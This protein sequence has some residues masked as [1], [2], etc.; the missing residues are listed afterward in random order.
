MIENKPRVSTDLVQHLE[1]LDLSM[2]RDATTETERQ[3]SM[4]FF[5][6]IRLYHRAVLWSIVLSTAIVMEGFDLVLI[7]SFFAFPQFTEHFG[8]RQPDGSYQVLSSWQSALTNGAL[9]GQILGLT[10]SGWIVERWGYRRT[11][12]LNLVAMI[13]FIFVPFFSPNIGVL[14]AGQV[15]CGIPWG[16]FQAIAPAYAADICPVSLRAYLTTYVNICFVTGQLLSTGI[17]RAFVQLNSQWAYRIPFALQWMWPVPILIGCFLAPES[18]WW[19][20][21]HGLRNEAKAVLLRL[22]SGPPSEKEADVSCTLAM[23]IYTNELERQQNEG[24]SYLECFQNTN[25]RRTEI[26][27]ITYASQMICGSSLMGYSVYFYQQAGLPTVQAL[28]LSIGQFAIGFVGTVLSWWLM[29][30]FGRRT[31]YITGTSISLIL[32]V[33]MGAVGVPKQ[34]EATAWVAGSLLLGLTF[35]YDVSIGP[36]TF[37][38]VAEVPS[39]RLRAKTVVIARCVYNISGI[40]CNILTPR[41]INPTAWG[42]G[43]KAG[44]FWAGMTLCCLVWMFFRLPEPKGC[45]YGELDI[46]FEQK[47]PARQF[48]KTKVAQFEMGGNSLRLK[49]IEAD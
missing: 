29:G 16:A 48:A 44:F 35:F 22:H 1:G 46:L 12:L 37:C 4:G 45:T 32:L 42:W 15:L 24:T 33:T 41:M 21:R 11:M 38:I 30:M 2:I 36:I 49:D 43:V 28:D 19:L 6:A 3:K 26:A 7:G 47:I 18:P 8:E 31:L 13:A 5:E 39:T 10:V 40:I 23:I 27:S 9:V 34:N 14:V 20:V 17:L 25:L